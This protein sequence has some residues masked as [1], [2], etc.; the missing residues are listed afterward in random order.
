MTVFRFGLL[1]AY[2]CSS[3]AKFLHFPITTGRSD[4]LFIPSTV[5]RPTGRPG[6]RE[7]QI[8]QAKA[9]QALLSFAGPTFVDRGSLN[10]RKRAKEALL[11]SAKNP[12]MSNIGEYAEQSD[13]TG[14]LRPPGKDTS[15]KERL[16]TRQRVRINQSS[17]QSKT[18]SRVGGNSPKPP[19]PKK[20][21]TILRPSAGGE[22]ILVSNRVNILTREGGRKKTITLHEDSRRRNPGQN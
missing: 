21:F 14:N 18:R 7:V 11:L 17:D 13:Q 16:R 8:E 2:L 5:I 15:D 1:L 19:P 9:A 20:R 4:R 10:P 6:L 3:T 22:G 12:E